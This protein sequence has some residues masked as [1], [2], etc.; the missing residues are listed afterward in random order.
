MENL[1]GV[2]LVPATLRGESGR[3]T[4]GALVLDS[5]AGYLALDH[6]VA[7]RLM[8]AEAREDSEGTGIADRALS[9]LEL[10]SLQIDRVEPVVT[11]EM[12][13]VRRVTDR[14]VLGLLG[15]LPL[16]GRAVLLDYSRHEV[17]L[18]PVARAREDSTANDSATGA[19]IGSAA[20]PDSAAAI[21]GSR[22]ALGRV[23]T[24]RAACVP[25]RLAG[26]GKILVSARASNPRP[27]HFSERLTLIVDSGA[28]K[29]VFFESALDERVRGASE[30]P[31]LRGLVAPTLEVVART[32]MVRVPSLEIATDAATVRAEGIDAAVIGGEFP[33]TVSRAVGEPVHG[34]LGYS[35]LK[36]F[37]L[38]IDYPHRVLWLDPRPRRDW[39]D[40]PY[41]Y[42][43]VGIQ[44]ERRGPSARVIAVA[45]KSPAALAGIQPGDEL[46]RVNGRSASRSNVVALSRLLEGPPGSRVRLTTRRGSMERE[47]RL[48]RR[49]L[50]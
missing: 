33:A 23:L 24:P 30:W 5:G 11:L 17:A 10:G 9:R 45:E 50:L 18:I 32:R 46:V 2:A 36:H 31:A 3:D 47:H 25:F 44:L 4:S 12:D 13:I 35:F 39:D 48:V 29:C 37:R 14:P 38:V 1:E 16:R 40:R 28:T 6:A 22:A 34:L 19:G 15:Q 49:R 7:A 42:C 27:P 41:E 26:D 8:I 21:A 43:Q 20:A